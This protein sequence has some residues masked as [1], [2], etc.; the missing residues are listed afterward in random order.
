MSR[1]IRSF[2]FDRVTPDDLGRYLNQWCEDA[3]AV[4]NGGIDFATNFNAN[5]I[6]IN[7]SA[8]N[9]DTPIAHGLAR[10]PN[11][12]ILTS[13]TAAI[14]LYDGTLATTSSIIYLRSSATGTATI[15]FY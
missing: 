2:D 3:V 6:T 1:L 8:A 4:I 15:L 9:T 13:A 11:R 12:Y 14:S 5:E 10:S 7:F